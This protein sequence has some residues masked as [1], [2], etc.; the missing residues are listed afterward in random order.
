MQ[1]Y[2]VNLLNGELHLRDAQQ[3]QPAKKKSWKIK[4]C[5]A[6]EQ[7]KCINAC[8]YAIYVLEQ[9]LMRL[10]NAFAR[11][12]SP[13]SQM[14]CEVGLLR[15]SSRFSFSAFLLFS[16]YF[17]RPVS[18]N[19]YKC[20]FLAIYD[21]AERVMAGSE[22]GPCQPIEMAETQRSKDTKEFHAIR[23]H[24]CPDHSLCSWQKSTGRTVMCNA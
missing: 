4:K 13:H 14:R 19:P 22:N 16:Q 21:C 24:T 10:E 3:H 5:R 9:T 12:T 18:Q 6:F 15:L 17:I 20:F 7:R 23:H 1:I 2:S 8:H 11:N